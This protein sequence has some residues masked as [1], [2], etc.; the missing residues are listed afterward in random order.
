MPRLLRGLL[1]PSCRELEN[2][3]CRLA[4]GGFSYP[5]LCNGVRGAV[6]GRCLVDGE[7]AFASVWLHLA[8]AVMISL[9]LGRHCAGLQ[10][11]VPKDCFKTSGDSQ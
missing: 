11:Q 4:K 2:S 6:L 5:M 8:Y 9:Q 7:T 10:M 1:V 3:T